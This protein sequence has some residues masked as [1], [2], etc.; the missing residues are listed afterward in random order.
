[1]AQALIES[2]SPEEVAEKAK[3]STSL[4]EFKIALGY[5]A[6]TA[7]NSLIAIK[8]YCEKYN[9]SLNHLYQNSKPVK[10]CPENI[11]IENST[12]S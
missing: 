5:G 12:A 1:M 4:K 9:I 7:G 10:R 6:N 2:F 3:N 8:K 11:F